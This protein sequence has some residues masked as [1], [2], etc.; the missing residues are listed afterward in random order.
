MCR[1]E[2]FSK[3]WQPVGLWQDAWTSH[4]VA[5]NVRMS[6]KATVANQ[7]LTFFLLLFRCGWKLACINSSFAWLTSC[8]DWWNIWQKTFNLWYLHCLVTATSIFFPHIETF[9]FLFFLVFS[10][11][12]VLFY[13][14]KTIISV[15]VFPDVVYLR[16]AVVLEIGYLL[17]QQST[18][19]YLF[20]FS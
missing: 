10:F 1:K 11:H 8:T 9:S 17:L 13:F 19:R 2:E 18:C 16:K 3:G 4:Q 7:V 14:P 15:D 6:V 12:V 20:L 5:C